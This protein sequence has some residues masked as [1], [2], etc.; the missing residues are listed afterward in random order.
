MDIEALIDNLGFI[1]S[2]LILSQ[3][4]YSV[5]GEHVSSQFGEVSFRG[6]LNTKAIKFLSFPVF[7]FRKLYCP[8]FRLDLG[9]YSLSFYVCKDSIYQAFRQR[10]I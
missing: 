5:I 2:V 3:Y 1:T 7:F 6:V 9:F 8:I 4:C 10:I